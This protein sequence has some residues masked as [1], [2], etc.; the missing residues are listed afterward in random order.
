M[1]LDLSLL[2]S[3]ES[4]FD[5]LIKQFDFPDLY[6]RSWNSMEE[7]LFYD[8]E[9][10]IPLKLVVVNIDSVKSKDPNLHTK[11]INWFNGFP[12]DSVEYKE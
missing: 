2:S 1:T 11:L 6:G 8:P 3:E 7:A 9:C 5:F 10:K 4:I 12:K